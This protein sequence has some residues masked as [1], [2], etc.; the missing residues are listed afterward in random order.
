MTKIL[1][2]GANGMLGH[3][4]VQ[5][6]GE[7]HDVYATVR[8]TFDDVE[9][10]G[11][12]DRDR[13]IE[14]IDVA[15]FTA[16]Q[17][18]VYEIR[19]DVI[20]NA[21]GVIKQSPAADDIAKMERINSLFPHLLAI[22]KQRIRCRLICISTDCV[23]DGQKGDYREGFLSNATDPYGKS[24]RMGEIAR[25][26]AITLR[27]SII[28]RELGTA[29]SLVEWFLA[30][31]GG[32]VKGYTNA[33]YSGFPTTVLA[34]IIENLI[35]EHADLRGLYHVS[36]DPINKYDLLV[37]INKYFNAG[38]EIE[39]FEDFRI[40]RSLNS[41]RFRAATGFKPPSWKELIKRMA[42][43]PTPYDSFRDK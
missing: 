23:F 30:N 18:T 31:R 36:S 20:I 32:K 24:K 34:D 3:K 28:G 33:I 14:K 10:Y 29:H 43:D 15:D 5:R 25:G 4:L 22:I 41:T 21:V 9:R 13:I 1:I 42:L 12:F 8:G 19:P 37:L 40:D 7:R 39:R 27:T 11:I 17:K 2:F 6:L 35:V 38:V 16:V 26:N